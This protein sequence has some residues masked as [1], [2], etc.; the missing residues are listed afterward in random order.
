MI[1][2][3]HQTWFEAMLK[4]FTNTPPTPEFIE[5]LIKD[6]EL[7][8]AVWILYGEQSLAF[9]NRRYPDL[10]TDKK[11]MNFGRKIIVTCQSS[12]MITTI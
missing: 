7:A 3:I 2:L 8:H 9:L 11:N 4:E 6:K 10:R 5:Q 1:P 12:K